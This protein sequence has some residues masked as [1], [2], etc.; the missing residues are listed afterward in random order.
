MQRLRDIELF[1]IPLTTT[2]L[3]RLCEVLST[4]LYNVELWFC[5]Y[6]ADYTVQQ[7][8]LKIHRLQVGLSG[9]ESIDT[10]PPPTALVAIVQR[11]L[12]SIA[13]LTL[14]SG[15]G[16][17]AYLGTM[18]RLT[19]LAT[20]LGSDGDDDEGLKNFLVANPQLVEFTLNQSFHKC[21]LLPP[22][23]LPN[24]RTIRV[25]NFKP[26]QHL[27]P[28]RPVAKVEIR[29][30]SK[31]KSIVK[32]LRALPRSTAPIVELTMRLH[33]HFTYL[34]DVLDAVVKV[35]PRLEIVS[36]SFQAEVRR[37]LY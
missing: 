6:P 20:D 10:G 13:T 12:S 18:P 27:I 36:L 26:I 34:Y 37:I 19:S 8:A 15:M 5:S 32:G 2:M 33:H 31:F 23:A 24:L 25:H 17:L 14:S 11:S 22:S 4:R 3:D 9:L 7:A 30:L 29:K 1:N 35:A 16:L 21:P 28:G